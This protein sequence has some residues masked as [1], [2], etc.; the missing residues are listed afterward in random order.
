MRKLTFEFI[1]EIPFFQNNSPDATYLAFPQ[2]KNTKLTSEEIVA[3]ILKTAR[4]ALIPGGA[5]WFESQ[6]EGHIRIC[7]STSEAILIEAF[8]RIKSHTNEFF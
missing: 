7:Y 4:V 5:S 2:L 6:S 3:K 1:D 8:D